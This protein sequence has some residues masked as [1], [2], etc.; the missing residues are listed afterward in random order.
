VDSCVKKKGISSLV[1]IVVY[2]EV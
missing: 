1:R 2:I